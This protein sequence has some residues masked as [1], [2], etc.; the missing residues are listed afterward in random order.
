MVERLRKR[1]EV[2]FREIVQRYHRS[3]VRLAHCFVNSRAAAEEV[4]Q[5]TW[6]G[7]LHGIDRFEGRSSL[8]SWIFRILTNR[9]K[10]RGAREGRNLP[11][12]VLWKPTAE[13]AEFAVP[14]E[15]F[16]GP[17]DEWPDHWATPPQGWGADPE[18]QLLARETRALIE[19]AIEALPP[20]QRE[21][22]TLRDVEGWTSEEVCNVLGVSETNQRVLLHRARS[23][24]RGALERHLERA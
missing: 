10:T 13:P 23:K 6:L 9:A 7:V 18:K 8:K 24:V 1:D 3:L 19:E 11:F 20:S 5:E 22:I 16:R 14:P 12:S 15:R 2:A 17:D 21:V 4:A